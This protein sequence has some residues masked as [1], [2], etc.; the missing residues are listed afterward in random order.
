MEMESGARFLA[1]SIHHEITPYINKTPTNITV[2]P[3]KTITCMYILSMK[4]KFVKGTI[5]NSRSLEPSGESLEGGEY[6][7]GGGGLNPSLI[8]GSGGLAR[9]FFLKSM[10]LRTHF[11]PF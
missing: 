2:E 9:K 7:R 6:E 10:Y 3:N 11:K 5:T 1:F 8:R 4:P